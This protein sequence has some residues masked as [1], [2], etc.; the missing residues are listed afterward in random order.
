MKLIVGLGNPGSEYHATRH[1]AGYM[2]LDEL[3]SRLAPGAAARG[4]FHAATLDA[5][6]QGTKLLL[7]K[8]TTYMNRSGL[9]VGEAAR[10]FK[11]DPAQDVLV[12]VDDVALPL[13]AI[14]L[15]E[16]GGDG[17][18]NGLA[19]ITRALAGASYARL[20]VG[21]DA[22]PQG[23]S[24]VGHVLGRFT[25]DQLERIRPGVTRAADCAIAWAL[26]GAVA[27]MN[28]FNAPP[29]GGAKA[30][31]Q[32]ARRREDEPQRGA[33]PSDQSQGGQGK[34]EPAGHQ[35]PAED[36]AKDST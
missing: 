6:A 13:G 11:L 14:R 33:A 8:P 21:V 17:G 9:A 2:V 36:P 20:R 27:A 28:E 19:D 26:R 16:R 3:A 18:H 29:Q 10:F 5:H 30:G 22:P 12:V 34:A 32:P 24:Q 35:R 15:R 25:A 1:N 7:M 31:K 23:A 4:R